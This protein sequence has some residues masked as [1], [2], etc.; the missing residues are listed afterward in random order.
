MFQILSITGIT[1]LISTLFE[2][3]SKFIMSKGLTTYIIY[4]IW[5]FLVSALASFVYLI[6]SF[7]SKFSEILMNTIE[8][9]NPTTVMNSVQNSAGGSLDSNFLACFS[10]VFYE[11]GFYD[12][13][14]AGI[15]IFLISLLNFRT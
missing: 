14:S 6:V 13:F 9:I 8:L 10:K 12:A 15:N 2:Y 3:I 11:L 4:I 7:Y 1:S 5:G